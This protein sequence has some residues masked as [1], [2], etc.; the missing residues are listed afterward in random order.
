VV[1]AHALAV[2]GVPRATADLDL[3]VEAS[4]TNAGLVV[5]ALAKFGAPLSALGIRREDFSQ[6][7]LVAQLGLPPFRVDLLTSISGVA[8]DEAWADRVMAEI[9]GVE[10]PVL[11][12]EAF[13]ANKRAT[14][15]KKDLADLDALSPDG[16]A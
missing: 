15:R 13:V 6:P 7:N 8:F 5:L 11:G 10:V 1:G 2:H 12:R 3:W 14:G 16:S 4:E 9:E